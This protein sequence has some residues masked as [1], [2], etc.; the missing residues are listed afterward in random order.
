METENIM[1]V[2]LVLP[3]NSYDEVFVPLKVFKNRSK[4][5]RYYQASLLS[6]PNKT[7][8]II[9]RKLL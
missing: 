5:E 1:S 7:I 3:T 8:N 2:W 9:E 6:A 4:A